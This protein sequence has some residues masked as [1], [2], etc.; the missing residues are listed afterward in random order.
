METI[1]SKRFKNIIPVVILCAIGLIVVGLFVQNPE[2]VSISAV[3]KKLAAGMKKMDARITRRILDLESRAD[4]VYDKLRRGNLDHSELEDRESLI[5]EKNGVVS[6]YYG[7]IFYFKFKDRMSDSWNLIRKNQD[8]YF[9]KKCDNHVYYVRFF[10][11]IVDNDCLSM[12]AYPFLEAEFKFFEPPLPDQLNEFQFDDVKL[13]FF[14]SHQMR[15]LNNQFMLFIKFSK[16]DIQQ[17]FKKRRESYIYLCILLFLVAGM[18]FLRGKSIKLSRYIFVFLAAAL[19]VVGYRL[20]SILVK[21]DLFIH[22]STGNIHS[23]YQVGILVF[24]LAVLLFWLSSIFRKRPVLKPISFLLFNGLVMAALILSSHILASLD[25]L[26]SDFNIAPAYLMLL[27]ILLV[28]HLIPFISVRFSF[29]DAGKSVGLVAVAGFQILVAAVMVLVFGFQMVSVISISLAYLVLLAL[30]GKFLTKLLVLFLLS[31]SIYQVIDHNG[32]EEKKEFIAQNLKPIFLNQ[33]NYAKLIA[34]EIVHEVNRYKDSFPDF[35]QGEHSSRL[36]AIWSGSLASQENIASGIFILSKA[37]KLKSSHSYLIPFLN[38]EPYRTF[39]LWAIEDSTAEIYGKK[40]SLAVATTS[41]FQNYDF[42]GRIIVQVLNS[43]ALILQSRNQHNIFTLNRKI[44]GSDLSYI[45]L[46]EENQILENPANINLKNIAGIIKFKD[47][48]I[49]FRFMNLNFTG[50]IFK[51]KNNAVI[52]FFPENSLMKRL[53]ELIRIFFLFSII[54]LLANLREMRSLQWSRIYYSFSIRV[55][56][57]LILISFLTAIIYSIFSADFYSRSEEIQ[58]RHAIL[59]R[60]RTAQNIGND[61]VEERGE[62]SLNQIFL[63]SSILNKDVSVYQNGEL[64]FTSNYRKIIRSTIPVFLHSN[65]LHLLNNKNQEFVLVNRNG[66]FSLFFKIYDYI[67][68]IE[69]P[70]SRKDFVSEKRQYT[71]FIIVLFFLLLIIGIASAFFFRNKIISPIQELNRGME[72]VERGNLIHL[73]EVPSEMELKSLYMGFNSMVDGIKEQKKSISEISRMKTLL[74]M[75]RR[76]A[77]E[78][79]N[80]LTPIKLSAEQILRSIKDK[81]QGYEQMIEKSVHFI[82]DESEHLKK[83]SYGFLDFSRLDEVNPEHFSLLEAV[84]EEVD[85]F[86]TLY[87]KINFISRKTG[88][89]FK[90]CWDKVKIKQVVKNILIN[91]IEAIGDRSGRIHLNIVEEA[92]RI[93]IE[94]SDNGIGLDGR[95]IELIFDEDYST[96]EIG[97]G[98]GLFIVKRIVELH[99]GRVEIKS[100]KNRGTT[101]IL[102]MPKKC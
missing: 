61:F 26:Y 97:T 7:E 11:D 78:V 6:D 81:R 45:T 62:L 27:I 46:N 30:D 14:Y 49:R 52:I 2:N 64:L 102:N 22:L 71:N 35:F 79:K 55:F 85:S 92:K 63:L 40:L 24:S 47:E 12:Q 60:G 17:F 99:Q 83:V 88:R 19:L 44:D 25:F 96:K 57:I 72:E 38:T 33:S 48:W 91:S 39:P 75:G 100:K 58:A 4:Y 95:E 3:R 29:K 67:F 20:V 90:V 43:S 13:R 1:L 66:G 15:S 84:N 98:L 42:L 8:I 5:I 56:V 77:H 28:L 54:F 69:F 73:E 18:F 50:Y 68:N 21:P 76:V 70:A 16:I 80:P 82:I 31:V 74:K 41:V 32:L 9:V 34:R 101:V 94:I 89:D 93:R 10:F 87:P 51:Q 86:K 23:I 37:G 65:M 36:E 59:E 53:S